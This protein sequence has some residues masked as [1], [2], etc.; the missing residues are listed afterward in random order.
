MSI[1]KYFVETIKAYQGPAHTHT[2]THTLTHASMHS[3]IHTHRQRKRQ[4]DRQI[5]SATH[6]HTHTHTH[7]Y[8]Y[9][10]IYIY[11]LCASG[12]QLNCFK[13]VT[14]TGKRLHVGQKA[15]THKKHHLTPQ[16]GVNNMCV[17]VCVCGWVCFNGELVHT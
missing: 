13:Y 16:L 14:P 10:Y 11:I 2:E 1:T 7:I 4:I 8:I 12:D 15:E 9:I 3:R 6:T 17:C 5:E